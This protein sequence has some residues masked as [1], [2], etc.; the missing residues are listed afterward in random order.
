[1]SE[2]SRLLVSLVLAIT[3]CVFAAA[4]I[5]L[6]SRFPGY[7]EERFGPSSP[8][9]LWWERLYLSFSLLANEDKL[10]SPV[11]ADGDP[12]LFQ[13]AP[14][15]DVQ[16][17]SNRLYEWGLIRDADTF[18][19]YLRYSGLDRKIQ[20]GD[21][22]VEPGWGTL[23]IAHTFLDATPAEVALTI[24]PGWRLEEIAV[25]LPTSGLEISPDQ[26]LEYAKN[27][28]HH[29]DG[30]VGRSPPHSL[31]G[32]FFPGTYTFARDISLESFVEFFIDQFDVLMQSEFK[33]A[34][35]EQGLTV[36]EG[37]ILASIVEKEAIVVEEQPL[38]ASVFYNRI[39]A[40]MRLESDPT[41]QYAIGYAPDQQ[42]WWKNPLSYAD[43]TIDSPY[44]TY[45]YFGLPPGPIGNP[46][47]TALSAVAFPAQT[48]YFYFR[49]SCDTSGTH[50]FAQTYEEHL[51]NACTNQE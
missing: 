20:A 7:V 28:D 30:L 18:G 5:Y 14:G 42:T 13:I 4:S 10:N 22:W 41:V 48:P 2:R 6:A 40:G 31:E 29:P 43:L 11:L 27:S 49:A 16:S 44:N 39:N 17:I 38:I 3:L 33:D 46:G 25:A 26:F 45:I 50:S 36:E 47:V 1:M 9:L 8:D 21:H 37:L 51:A 35:N 32:I 23:Q 19:L 15:E 12:L 24:F 34:F